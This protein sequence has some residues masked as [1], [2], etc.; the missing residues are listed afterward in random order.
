MRRFHYV[1]NFISESV[2]RGRNEHHVESTKRKSSTL[3]ADL[4]LFIL[5]PNLSKK[6]IWKLD[7]MFSQNLLLAF[8]IE[9]MIAYR[10]KVSARWLSFHPV[11]LRLSHFDYLLLCLYNFQK[12]EMRKMK[13]LNS[14]RVKLCDS[15]DGEEEVLV[16][17]HDISIWKYAIYLNGE[18][19]F[20]ET[21][22][23]PPRKMIPIHWEMAW[24]LYIARWYNA[25]HTYIQRAPLIFYYTLQ[26][27]YCCLSLCEPFVSV[28]FVCMRQS[29][30]SH[31]VHNSVTQTKSHKIVII[32][33]IRVEN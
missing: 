18:G 25:L 24:A 21:S 22:P 1:K 12:W 9:T 33:C 14:I 15:S 6:I 11:S 26:K 2:F 10:H 7:F 30:R 20:G 23:P 29:A 4:I 28:L 16:A 31:H 3:R 32:K 27:R 17:Y 13:T 5:Q 19:F 8:E